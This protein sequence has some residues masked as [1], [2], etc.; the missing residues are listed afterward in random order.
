MR[1]MRRVSA[2]DS[3]Q[4][5]LSVGVEV[6]INLF[7]VAGCGM[8]CISIFQLLRRRT[9]LWN[10]KGHHIVTLRTQFDEGG[11]HYT[12]RQSEDEYKISVEN[13]FLR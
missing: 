7:L 12:L 8:G 10:S 9:F 13:E 5:T 1:Q 6:V 3:D 2:T 11:N 4:L